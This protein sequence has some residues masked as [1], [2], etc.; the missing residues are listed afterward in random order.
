MYDPV[1]VELLELR[2]FEALSEELHYGHAAER[3]GVTASTLSRRIRALE[4]KLGVPLF[5]RTSRMVGLTEAGRE[6]A[7]RLPGALRQ[8]DGVLLAA[9]S[10]SDGG[11][12]V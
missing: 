11:W 1:V 9:R 4:D 10:A 5:V 2:S 12:E 6:L 7:T 8:L 3:L